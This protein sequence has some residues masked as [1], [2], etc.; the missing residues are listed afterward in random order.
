VMGSIASKSLRYRCEFD[1]FNIL[2]E[3]VHSLASN[4]S[5]AALKHL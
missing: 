2:A 3:Q 4:H 1:I 5:F